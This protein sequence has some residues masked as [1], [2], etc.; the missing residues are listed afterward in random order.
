VKRWKERLVACVLL[1][2]FLGAG[3]VLVP[4]QPARPAWVQEWLASKHAHSFEGVTLAHKPAT[5][6]ALAAAAPREAAPHRLAVLVEAAVVHAAQ[7]PPAPTPQVR[8]PA[9]PPAPQPPQPVPGA[10]TKLGANQWYIIDSDLALV[11]LTSP[12]GLVGVG[13]EAGPVKMRGWFVDAAGVETR[14]YQGKFIYCLD[15]TGVGK[16]EL[17]IIRSDNQ[18]VIRRWLD[19]DNGGPAPP[20]VPP[21]PKPDPPSPAPIPAAGL[22]VLIV[23]ETADATKMPVA[24]QSILYGKPFRDYLN[25][26]CALGPDGKTRE[27]RI[28]DQN[29][30]TSAESKTWQDAMARPRA[31]VPWLVVSNGKAGWEG[32]LPANVDAAMAIIKKFEQ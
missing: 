20:P 19:V 22:R 11:V 8:L 5:A 7:Q 1:L 28:W 31:S 16:V 14:T 21:G 24:Q 27:W 17:L 2:G 26:K 18:E 29:V 12:P 13:K 6:T 23:Y 15:A 10:A 4:Q 25:A 9:T 32:P 3:L 30:A